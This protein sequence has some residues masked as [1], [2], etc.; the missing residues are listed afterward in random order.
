M[1]DFLASRSFAS[2]TAEE[3]T[4]LKLLLA[5]RILFE[6]KQT[7]AAFKAI[8]KAEKLALE[9][10]F[11]NILNEIYHTL[12]QYANLNSKV[13]LAILT[14]KLLENGKKYIKQQQLN[15]AYAQIKQRL[16][17]SKLNRSPLEIIS[18]ILA[19]YDINNG[20]ELDF[21]STYQL[22]EICNTAA[23]VHY[24]YY[25]ILPTM[26]F[27]FKNIEK[28]QEQTEKH[29]FYNIKALFIMANTLLR[30]K[31]FAESLLYL[32][33]IENQLP[34]KKAIY[35]SRFVGQLNLLQGL[36]HHYT[37]KI[38]LAT[39]TLEQAIVNSKKQH[40]LQY[41]IKLSLVMCHFQQ[42][43]YKRALKSLN[44]LN[45]SNAYFEKKMG[46]E[47][48]IKKD[49]ME[50]LLVIELDY[51]DLVVSRLRSFRKS[52]SNYL[53]STGETR[54]LQFIN[55][56]NEYY[57]DQNKVQTVSFKKKVDESFEFIGVKEEDLFVMSFYAWLKSKMERTN[58]YETTLK[59]I[60]RAS[61][62]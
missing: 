53:K 58:L 1:I 12:I 54:S 51:F 5:S 36:N 37:G 14:T 52:H 60:T 16:D 48:V 25:E 39:T 19:K 9:N 33:Q 59:L 40:R 28:K 6:R 57:K 35:R 61:S 20:D 56:V 21:K 42:E 24:N 34:K 32:T 22:M 27:L 17:K 62:E 55:L 2:E 7:K 45:H 8:Y 31:L 11:F 38:D 49:I 46:R 4:I 30:N 50:I 44:D 3:M 41:D 29:L 15:I 13:D 10:E 47:W 43:T 18:N 23:K 26:R